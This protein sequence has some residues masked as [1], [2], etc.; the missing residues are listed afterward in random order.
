MNDRKYYLIFCIL[1]IVLVGIIFGIDSIMRGTNASFGGV[2]G[3]L[4][5]TYKVT[6]Y[7]N[8]PDD[9]MD[10]ESV[11]YNGDKIYQILDNMFEVPSGYKFLGWGTESD[12][13]V[14]YNAGHVMSLSDKLDLY[15]IWE[16]V[17]TDED[18]NTEE[19]VIM[20]GDTNLDG[21][22]NENDYLLIDSYLLDNSLLSGQGLVNADVNTDGKVDNI[23]SDIIKQAILGTEGY[24]EEFVAIVIFPDRRDSPI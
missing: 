13:Q 20:Y 12:G 8:F 5:M 17:D 11:S 18:D 16:F 10:D 4:T 14:V 24:G 15:A 22:V 6:Y 2:T 7:A 1:S 3:E 9:S 19:T 21:V 23:D